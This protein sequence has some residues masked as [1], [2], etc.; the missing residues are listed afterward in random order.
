ME[1]LF[2]FDWFL[3]EIGKRLISPNDL[4]LISILCLNRTINAKATII[5]RHYFLNFNLQKQIMNVLKSTTTI[6]N[7]K[8]NDCLSNL[9]SIFEKHALSLNPNLYFSYSSLSE[10]PK[11]THD[12]KISSLR[13]RRNTAACEICT[14]SSTI[15]LAV[16]ATRLDFDSLAKFILFH[17]RLNLEIITKYES[18]EVSF[19]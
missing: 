6:A 16:I 2:S 11:C 9:E 5:F 19:N 12:P 18:Q 3:I 13:L 7:L 15:Q 1:P 4:D 17:P 8:N 14:K 10:I